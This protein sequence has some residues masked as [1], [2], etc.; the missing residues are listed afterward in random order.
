MKRSEITTLRELKKLRDE[1][2]LTEAEFSSKKRALLKLQDQKGPQ[3]TRSTWRL[4][5]I[6]II[7]F[8][9]YV[10]YL[11]FE[12]RRTLN[13]ET[14]KKRTPLLHAI[15]FLIPLLGLYPLYRLSR[16]L[17][18]LYRAVKLPWPLPNVAEWVL[19]V[20]FGAASVLVNAVDLISN[21]DYSNIPLWLLIVTAVTAVLAVVYFV[22]LLWSFNDY[23][24]AKYSDAQPARLGPDI[25][26]SYVWTVGVFA[27][28]M[29]V[30]S[31]LYGTGIISTPEL[32]DC[33]SRL[34]EKGA[35]VDTLTSNIAEFEGTGSSQEAAALR[36][37]LDQASAEY[38]RINTEC[39][40]F[41]NEAFGF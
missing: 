38:G 2:V 3:V 5:G 15:L 1:G 35:Q 28:M 21:E 32:D 30:V 6:S 18:S 34:D 25:G 9:G 7:T 13:A 27:A 40:R 14:G 16:D 29:L 26:W 36:P 22:R 19:F 24:R 23:C 4:I 41:E 11:F 17:R 39:R 8:G 12:M 31:L 37:K 10:P 20:S 33:Y